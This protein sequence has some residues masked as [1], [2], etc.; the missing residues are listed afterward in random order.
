M[1]ASG[2]SSDDSGYYVINNSTVAAASGATVADGA[3][4]LG[5]PWEDYARVVFQLTSMTDIINSAGWSEW[6]SSEPNTEH[7]TF[8]TE[9]YAQDLCVSR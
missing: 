8:G 9:A 3:M 7:V 4:Y 1:T 5:R 2:R 6:S